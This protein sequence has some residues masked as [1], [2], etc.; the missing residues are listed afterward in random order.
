M[1]NFSYITAILLAFTVNLYGQQI[2]IDTAH[3]DVN[4]QG[5]VIEPHLGQSS[6][7]LQGGTITLKNREFLNGTI[8]YDI[9]LN[10]ERAYPGV[11]FR[12]QDNLDA[13]EFYVRTHLSGKEDATQAIPMVQGVSPWQLYFGPRYSFPY[14]FQYDDW[15]HI[16][17]VVREDKAQ[18]F[19]DY[20]ATPN[21]SWELTNPIQPGA[22]AFNGGNFQGVHYA[23][24]QIKD[25][26][27]ELIDFK[28][29][30]R[31]REKGLVT[32]WEISEKFEEDRLNDPKSLTRLLNSVKWQGTL[33]VEEGTAANISRIQKLND[34]TPGNTVF[35]RL[36]IQS[37]KDQIKKLDFGYSD[38]VLAILNG[39]PIYSGSNNWRSRDYRYLGTIGLFDSIYLHLKKGRNELVMA[40]S[41]DFGGWLITGKF[42]DLNGIKVSQD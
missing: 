27:P 15:T 25:E 11:Y 12:I 1:K 17:I 18:V 9:H 32:A 41:E 10:P 31:Q 39:A 24:I 30:E 2:P 13:E 29:I 20:S 22:I 34:G 8:E 21:L 7:Y 42:D 4:A 38:R 16:K 40:V 3:W 37:D 19:M 14:D 28:P 5:Y 23:N 36:I 33:G 6:I 35:A 26:T